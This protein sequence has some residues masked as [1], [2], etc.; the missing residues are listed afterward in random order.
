MATT[1]KIIM[2]IAI[3]GIIAVTGFY[4]ALKFFKN[5]IP[6][7]IS[8]IVSVE[9][10]EPVAGVKIL[11]ENLTIPWDIAFLP[12]NTLLVT[13]R[14]GKLLHIDLSDGIKR[15]FEVS[16]VEHVGEGGLLGLAL[17]PQFKKNNL[18]YLYMTTK[19]NSGLMNR[20]IRYKFSENSLSEPQVILDN[21]P[22][23]SFHDGGALNF[24]S[25]TACAS[26][27]ADCYL[28]I[29]TG[30][31]GDPDAA[32][33]KNSLSGKILRIKDDGSSVEIWSYGHR[34]PQGLAWDESGNLWETEHG[35]STPVWPNCC[36]D[37]INLIVQGSNYGW[38]DSVGDRVLDD[39]TR[40]VLHSGRITWAPASAAYLNGSL[41]FGGLRGEALYEAVI[42]DKK[43]I[44]LKE[45]FKNQFGR[46]RAVRLGPD[47]MLYITTSNRDNRGSIN[48]GDDKLIRVDPSVL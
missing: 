32:Q 24:G 3:I 41:F 2:I 19:I 11:A 17:H 29:T 1:H 30:D 44:K 27:Q 14:G 47:G 8:P 9:E 33:D 26:E 15:I 20:I 23:S 46:I 25:P 6:S 18:L 28:Y 5:E 34:N 35:P 12:D 36:Q 10:N 40:P 16:G 38:P 4:F 43:V 7:E 21:I 22:G 31:A 42:K 13:E 45:H 39:T 37:E 48:Q